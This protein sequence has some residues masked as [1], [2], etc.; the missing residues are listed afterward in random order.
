MFF[1]RT[2]WWNCHS[3]FG[4]IGLEWLRILMLLLAIILFLPMLLCI[5]VL[6]VL[7]PLFPERVLKFYEWMIG[8][9]PKKR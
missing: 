3:F 2:L 9:G 4:L 5:I 7:G 6:S 1:L 8:L